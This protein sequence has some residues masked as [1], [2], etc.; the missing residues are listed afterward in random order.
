MC[1]HLP[2]ALGLVLDNLLYHILVPEIGMPV[3]VGLF[4]NILGFFYNLLYHILVPEILD[5]S[6]IKGQCPSTWVHEVV[7][8]YI[9][10]FC[11]QLVCVRACVRVCE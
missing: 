5:I 11:I 10:Y 3:S 7:P 2:Q 6:K 4:A 9:Y 1:V 8:K